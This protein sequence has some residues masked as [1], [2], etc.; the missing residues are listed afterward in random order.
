MRLEDLAVRLV[1]VEA[2]V[3]SLA[4]Y[5]ANPDV[6]TSLEELNAR[7]GLLECTVEI[8]VANKTQEQ[9]AAIVAAPA[10]AADGTPVVLVEAVVALSASADV[11]AAADIVA[12][13]VTAQVEALSV[14][15]TEVANIIAAAVMAVVEANPEVVVDTAAITEAIMTAVAEMPAPAPEVAAEAAAAVAEI[16]AAATGEEVAPEVAQQV[17]EAVAAPADPVLTNIEH[18][19]NVAEAK[20]D[21]LLGK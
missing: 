8:L 7:L 9:V 11:P 19:L 2:K 3:A 12:D 14:E 13:V 10:V 18:R 5:G 16:I 20:V 1:A 15:H 4:G 17:A 21:S 6:A